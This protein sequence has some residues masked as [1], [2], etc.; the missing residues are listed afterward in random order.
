VLVARP[1]LLTAE[2][3]EQ[4]E[5]ELADG[6]SI[7]TVAQHAG[8]SKRTL[9]SWLERG[10]VERRIEPPAELVAELPPLAPELDAALARA[11]SESRLLARI[12]AHAHAGE[13]TSWRAAAWLLEREHPSKWG[14]ERLRA[15]EP[16]ASMPNP[17]GEVLDELDEL[18]R[19][20]EARMRR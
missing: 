8:V 13:P 20:R 4:I 17:M 3:R 10:R 18:R 14:A 11:T 9:H 19:R 2:L 16:A 5:L 15:R 12:A 6:A 1:S 7:A